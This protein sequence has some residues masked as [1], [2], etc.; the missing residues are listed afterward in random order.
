M[1][2][3]QP[4]SPPQIAEMEIERAADLAAK[5]ARERTVL[6]GKQENERREL[7]R[8]QLEEIRQLENPTI[9]LEPVTDIRPAS[10]GKT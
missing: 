10:G 1:Q 7:Q 9:G 6:G 4:Q 2:I 5:H 3:G 8:R